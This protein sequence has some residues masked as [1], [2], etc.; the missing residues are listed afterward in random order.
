MS[1]SHARQ[2]PSVTGMSAT[3]GAPTA[4]DGIDS[5]RIAY[6]LHDVARMLSLSYRKVRYMADSGEL[7]FFKVGRVRRV[8]ASVVEA[9]IR[10]QQEQ[11]A[12]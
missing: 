10:R 4:T 9:Y 1:C 12:S 3:D 7:E 2:W 6:T 8:H 11:R 5:S